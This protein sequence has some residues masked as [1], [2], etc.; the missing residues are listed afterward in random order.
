MVKILPKQIE[1]IVLSPRVTDADAGRLIRYLVTGR[2]SCPEKL[3][4]AVEIALDNL[5]SS[6]EAAAEQKAAQRSRKK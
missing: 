6:R 1:Q 2:G 5:K 3:A 4:L